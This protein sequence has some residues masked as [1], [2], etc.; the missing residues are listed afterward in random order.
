M[1]H[2]VPASLMAQRRAG[3]NGCR[4]SRIQ[5][6]PE[7]QRLLPISATEWCFT[8]LVPPRSSKGAPIWQTPKR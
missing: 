7:T 2:A 8:A 6:E 5:H 3:D 4:T 1:R